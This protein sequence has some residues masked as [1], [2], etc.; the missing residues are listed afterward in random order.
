VTVLKNVL[1]VVVL[2]LGL[3]WP[4]VVNRAPILYPDSAGYYRAGEAALEVAG[5]AMPMHA[6]ESA[7]ESSVRVP[8]DTAGD[9]VSTKR[10]VYYGLV[11]A[12][13]F[14]LG[15]ASLVAL[16]Q[17]LAVA[18]SVFLALKR[19]GVREGRPL[20]LTCLALV[21]LSGL[22]VFSTAVMP[23]VFLGVM[24]LAVALLFA[25]WDRMHLPAR[26]WFLLMAASAVLFHMAHLAVLLIMIAGGVVISA[27]GRRK[28]L[29]AAAWLGAIAVGAAGAHSAVNVVVFRVTGE[30]PVGTPFLLARLVG[31]GT[32][33][34]YLDKHCAT[35]KLATCA[36]RSRMPMTENDFLWIPAKGAYAAGDAAQ[37]D[38]INR[39]QG[40]I[41]AGTVREFPLQQF[42]ASTSNAARQFVVV[43]AAEFQN[44]A[45]LRAYRE[46]R[47][48]DTYA[49]SR[50]ANGSNLLTA[51]SWVMAVTYFASLAVLAGAAVVAVHS[52]IR[53]ESATIDA[54]EGRFWTTV[55]IAIVG[56]GANA[57]VCGILSGVFDRYQGRAAW[58]AVILAMVA[59][60]HPSRPARRRA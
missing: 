27:I 58:V 15:G 31:D 14:V 50:I 39:E 3:L 29:A 8:I 25:H 32:A 41:V 33:V 24:I 56:L 30:A 46:P 55:S 48:R 20:V 40:V 51:I 26:A 45:A 23:D 42:V 59:I 10:S 44:S 47:I 34:R 18:L 6:G 52:R 35:Q 17:S 11:I 22:A 38:R 54:T 5:V 28:S 36:F 12:P 60:V 53:G 21:S 9:G 13:L 49:Q 43:G 16:A 1:T 2:A 37:R 7:R 57:A 19:M 4:A